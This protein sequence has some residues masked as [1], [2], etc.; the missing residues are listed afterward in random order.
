M[1]NQERKTEYASPW[2]F[3]FLLMPAGIS[4]GF[5]CVT[6]PFVLAEKNF[7]VATIG[8]ITAIG[9]SANL[10]R[11]L[12]AP[13]V[14]TTLS[15]KKWFLA[16]GLISALAMAVFLLLPLDRNHIS[17]IIGLTFISQVAATFI[18]APVSAYMAKTVKQEKKGRAAG[19]FQAG[20]LGGMG[21]GGGAGIWLNQHMNFSFAV[22]GLVLLSL[23]SMLIILRMPEIRA[24]RESSLFKQ[25]KAMGSDLLDLLKSPLA[26]FAVFLVLSPIG[27]GAASNLWS[28]IATEWKV[29]ADNVALVTGTLS[30]LTGILGC[31]AGGWITDHLSR[32]WSY[33]GG[34]VLAALITLAMMVAGFLPIYYNAGVLSYSFAI[35]VVNAGFSGLLLHALGSKGLVSTK[36]SLMSS[37]GNVPVVYMTAFD[38]WAH[39]KYGT[40]AMLLGES[41][42][43][44]LFVLL[45]LVILKKT[46]L[47]KKQAL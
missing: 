36:Y 25:M 14:D 1:M 22:L 38:G 45:F 4:I 24:S 27:S 21:L 13:I 44:I 16:G 9:A 26:L 19:W 30:G 47:E 33:F 34:G 23:L 31:V 2:V 10:Y 29:N 17:L 7:P 35:G 28:S 32:W 5:A 37:I 3:I 18:M 43:G 12:W 40:K 8:Y 39:D 6:L 20:N 46:G 15:L 11:F 41:V 42:A